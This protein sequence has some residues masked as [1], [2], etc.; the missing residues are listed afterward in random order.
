[1]SDPDWS[2]EDGDEEK[3]LNW[4]GWERHLSP[5]DRWRLVLARATLEPDHEGDFAL[6]YARKNAS[7]E[8]EDLQEAGDDPLKRALVR[9][10]AELDSYPAR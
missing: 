6:T 4:H 9:L 2:L 5:R 10:E 7:A 8:F 1:M 3:Y